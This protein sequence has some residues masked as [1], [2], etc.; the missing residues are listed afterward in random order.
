MEVSSAPKFNIIVEPN[1]WA[2]ITLNKDSKN[3]HFVKKVN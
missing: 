1:E 3:K 2:E